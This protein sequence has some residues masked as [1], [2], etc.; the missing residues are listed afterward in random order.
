MKTTNI[1]IFLWIYFCVT[2]LV[3]VFCFIMTD[4]LY[5]K[6]TQIHYTVCNPTT[7][8]NNYHSVIENDRV[9]SDKSEGNYQTST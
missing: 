6:D 7:Y 4:N 9:K 5:K 8:S 3:L 2:F 1:N